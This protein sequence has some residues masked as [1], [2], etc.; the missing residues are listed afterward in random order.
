VTNN[1]EFLGS[2]TGGQDFSRA[3]KSESPQ[4]RPPCGWWILYQTNW[5]SWLFIRLNARQPKKNLMS[6]L[7]VEL[8]LGTELIVF[9]VFVPVYIYDEVSR[10]R[11]KHYVD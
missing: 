6:T 10:C 3:V 4:L 11:I 9:I 8:A 7:V 1:S 5:R 2:A